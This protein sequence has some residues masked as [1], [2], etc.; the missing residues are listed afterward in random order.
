M[1]ACMLILSCI[2]AAAAWSSNV[3]KPKHWSAW[4]LDHVARRILHNNF[5]LWV[6]P[7]SMK[8]KSP[9]LLFYKCWNPVPWSRG[10]LFKTSIPLKF[11]RL[12]LPEKLICC[13][14]QMWCLSHPASARGYLS[15]V[16]LALM[17]LLIL[18]FEWH[19]HAYKFVLVSSPGQ[20][21]RLDPFSHSRWGLGTRL[22]IKLHLYV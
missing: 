11:G 3:L 18:C 12:Q 10:I 16:W 14:W 8:Y 21:F 20:D 4:L 5:I 15:P 1:A 17:T 9:I 7:M 13:F 19:V 6:Q 2:W 22:I